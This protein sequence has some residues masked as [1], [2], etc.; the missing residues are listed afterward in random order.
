V[1]RMSLVFLPVKVST[2]S[3]VLWPVQHICLHA[4]Y[5]PTPSVRTSGCS[6]DGRRAGIVQEGESGARTGMWARERMKCDKVAVML[7]R[8]CDD[9]CDVKG[10]H[11]NG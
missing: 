2:K 8:I 5:S 1:L 4:L 6:C 3:H 10:L 11:E 9:K 7:R